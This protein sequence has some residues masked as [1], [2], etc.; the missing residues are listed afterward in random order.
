MMLDPTISLA[1]VQLSCPCG[2][3][4]QRQSLRVF[5]DK[6]GIDVLSDSFVSQ[7]DSKPNLHCRHQPWHFQPIA[8]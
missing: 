8:N 5:L 2:S 3:E 6:I 4:S 7:Q 1:Y